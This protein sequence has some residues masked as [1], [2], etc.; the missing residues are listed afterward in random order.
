MNLTTAQVFQIGGILIGLVTALVPI[1][2]PAEAQNI[3]LAGGAIASA[4]AA[5]GTAL[6]GQ[7]AQVRAVSNFNG[8]ESVK[9]TDQF[10]QLA[11]DPSAPNVE[12]SK[13]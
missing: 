1:F 6:T 9:V 4:W 3:A 2:V 8:V 11:D 10:K 12:A 5:I 13:K 7:S